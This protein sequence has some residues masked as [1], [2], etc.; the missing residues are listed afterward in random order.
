[1][2]DPVRW[3]RE[4]GSAGDG[5]RDL[6]CLRDTVGAES[7]PA[8][9]AGSLV[10]AGR[11]FWGAPAVWGLGKK[12]VWVSRGFGV[13]PWGRSSYL[14]AEG[15]QGGQGL[16][17]EPAATTSVWILEEYLHP[18]QSIS[19]NTGNLRSILR[20]YSPFTQDCQTTVRELGLKIRHEEGELPFSGYKANPIRFNGFVNGYK[21]L[22]V[23]T[24]RVD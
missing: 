2:A 6:R 7:A 17:P 9:G 12:P 10:K 24:V 5:P 13:R 18:W 11:L 3:L 21:I 14:R 23:I 4:Q 1:M 16:S 19:E 22:E 15:S 8:R 20:V